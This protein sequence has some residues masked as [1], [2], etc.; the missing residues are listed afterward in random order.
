MAAFPR[1]LGVSS[2][3]SEVLGDRVHLVWPGDVA[4]V[5]RTATRSQNGRFVWTRRAG[6]GWKKDDQG[7]SG[8]FET[9]ESRI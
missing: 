6:E 1:E 7:Q 8:P 2:L 3:A 9:I 4:W 5:V